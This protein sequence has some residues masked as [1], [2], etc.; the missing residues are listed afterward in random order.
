MIKDRSASTAKSV[1]NLSYIY[2][3]MKTYM[4]TY[5]YIYLFKHIHI[6]VGS[7]DQR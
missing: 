7:Y 2:M 6:F 1:F 3:Y 4:H 5:I